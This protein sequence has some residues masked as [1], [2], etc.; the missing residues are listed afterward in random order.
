MIDVPVQMYAC[1]YA[2]RT[3]EEAGWFRGVCHDD[4]HMPSIETR[5][6]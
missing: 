3:A 4:V 6:I 5:F 1:L 2:G